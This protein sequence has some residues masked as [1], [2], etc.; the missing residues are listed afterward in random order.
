MSTDYILP[1]GDIC[2]GIVN[3]GAL[4]LGGNNYFKAPCGNGKFIVSRFGTG[5]L[6]LIQLDAESSQLLSAVSPNISPFGDPFHIQGCILRPSR[7]RGQNHNGKKNT[8]PSTHHQ[9]WKQ[10]QLEYRRRR[11]GDRGC[12]SC[13]CSIQTIDRYTPAVCTGSRSNNKQSLFRKAGMFVRS[14]FQF[15]GKTIQSTGDHS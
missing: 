13:P 14:L 11:S 9:A 15:T 5:N 4:H 2:I 1:P 10:A 7:I 6:L 12:N 8:E 3:D